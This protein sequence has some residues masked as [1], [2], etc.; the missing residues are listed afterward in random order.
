MATYPSSPEKGP[1]SP[2][3]AAP[4]SRTLQPIKAEAGI[5]DF[6]ENINAISESGSARA[7]EDLPAKSG[8]KAS[9]TTAVQTRTQ[10]REETL[11]SLPAP[12]VMQKEIAKHIK[13][14]V[15]KLRR[16]ARR[17]SRVSQAG[18]AHNLSQLYA[19][20]HRLNALL[21]ELFEASI[22]VLKRLYVRIFV[23]RQAI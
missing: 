9:G 23:D 5:R 19:R 3:S 2:S 6:L 16:E 22:D 8:G 7:G 13:M 14:E 4:E 11:A 10:T 17:V 1:L 12:A 15:K 20:I 21:H 18:G